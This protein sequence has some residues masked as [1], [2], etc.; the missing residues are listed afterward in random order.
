MLRQNQEGR[1]FVW[2]R[3]SKRRTRHQVLQTHTITHRT[4]LIDNS[5]IP[6]FIVCVHRCRCV[7]L[8][9]WK[10]KVIFEYCFPWTSY[11]PSLLRQSLTNLELSLPVQLVNHKAPS[12]SA[13]WPM[14]SPPLDILGFC[15]NIELRSSCLHSKYIPDLITASATWLFLYQVRHTECFFLPI[16]IFHFKWN[17]T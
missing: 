12:V 8:C 16:P 2:E 11:L 13:L 5:F 15:T 9:S 4:Q 17:N 7:H 14:K 10:S 3:I 1:I 6:A